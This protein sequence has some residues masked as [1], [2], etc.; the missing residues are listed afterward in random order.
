M[1]SHLSS[2][3]QIVIG[4]PIGI[5]TGWIHFT[6]LHWNVRLLTSGASG[7]A[8][9]LQGARL[10]VLV[11]IFFVLATLGPWVLLAGAAGL[12]MVRFA[13]LRQ[14]RVTP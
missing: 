1:M 7:R 4:L 2:M 9:C 13:V 3:L 5:G 10:A 6:T 8:I 12:L 11:L 14:V